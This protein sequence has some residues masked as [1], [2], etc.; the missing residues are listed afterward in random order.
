[1]AMRL[2]LIFFYVIKN[3][4]YNSIAG[5]NNHIFIYSLHLSHLPHSLYL[6]YP[7]YLSYQPH[8]TYLYLPYLFLFF[9][10]GAQLMF[11]LVD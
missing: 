1:M 10:I 7:P 4:S 3:I 6:I 8:S 11:L 9:L 5:T 2:L